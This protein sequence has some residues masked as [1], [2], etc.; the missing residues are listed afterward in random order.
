MSAASVAQLDAVRNLHIQ[1]EAKATVLAE[2]VVKLRARV[3]EL[4]KLSERKD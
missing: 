4:E 2:E 3:Q 1:A